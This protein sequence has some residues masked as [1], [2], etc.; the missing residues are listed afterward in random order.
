VNTFKGAIT[1]TTGIDAFSKPL[2][3]IP[4]MIG[5]I[6]KTFDFSV[7]LLEPE[8]WNPI[9]T[10]IGFIAPKGVIRLNQE[11]I[12]FIEAT[13]LGDDPKTVA[14]ALFSK[15]GPVL[16]LLEIYTDIDE[17]RVEIEKMIFSAAERLT[18][19]E[20]T[21]PDDLE[22]VK[23]AFLPAPPREPKFS[24]IAEILV[25]EHLELKQLRAQYH[26]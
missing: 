24:G 7:R 18:G 21:I 16:L 13:T 15:Y 12:L 19:L 6:G 20:L 9:I 3:K 2:N 8:L 22:T 4:V 23:D 25:R 17:G 5:E 14:H 11:G 10:H 26:G 1:M